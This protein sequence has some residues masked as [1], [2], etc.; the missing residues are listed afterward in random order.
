M[1]KGIRWFWL[2][3]RLA[4]VVG[5]RRHQATI[6]LADRLLKL[7]PEDELARQLRRNAQDAMQKEDP[8]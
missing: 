1:L 5:L 3:M 4:T 7:D 8:S 2:T 6:E